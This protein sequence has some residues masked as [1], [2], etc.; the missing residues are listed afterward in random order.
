VAETG[1]DMAAREP[2]YNAAEL[3]RA[4]DEEGF[5][6]LVVRSGR[7]V[8]YLSGMRFPGTL[9]RLQ[10][11]AH[12]PRAAL[13]VWPREGAPTLIAST[14]AAGV[15]RRHSWVDD[16]RSFIEYSESPFVLAGRVVKERRLGH[17]RIGVERRE[18]GA[19]Q[20]EAFRAELPDAELVDCTDTLEAVRNIKTPDELRLLRAAVEIQDAAHL[21][22]F[23]GARAGDTE[24]ELHARMIAAMLRRGAESAHGMMQASSNPVTY[25]GEGPTVLRRG[26]ALRTDY[27][28]YVD[29][30]AANLSRMAVIGPPGDTQQ[31]MYAILRDTHRA[32]IDACLRPGVEAQDVYAFV[33][34]RFV[35]AGFPNVAG[36]V[37]HS[38]G[39]WWHQEEPM[40]VPGERRVLR[41]GMVVCLEPILDGF[42][43][44]QDE[45]MVQESGPVLLSDMF[46]TSN[47]FV[48]G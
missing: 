20:W 42:W 6:A 25:G 17:G 39:V 38:I 34:D 15:A 2:L 4:L 44:V 13:T 18:M 10:D 16:I 5:D 36:L 9:G 41:D 12:S 48:I 11:F 40:L 19:D 43:H 26:D 28:C 23:S 14:I 37:G 29:G 30:Y 45:I 21:E 3:R 7:N 22:V 1:T 47:L 31:A 8:A 46:D 35:A 33:R 27:V 32:T 24:R